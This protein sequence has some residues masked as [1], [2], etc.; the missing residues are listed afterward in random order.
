MWIVNTFQYTRPCGRDHFLHHLR[1]G[2]KFQ[3]TLPCGRDVFY[4][5]K[6]SDKKYFNTLAHAGETMRNTL[7]GLNIIF[8]YTRP[9]GRDYNCQL[10]YQS[11][12][13]I[14]IHSPMRARLVRNCKWWRF[15]NFNTLAHAGETANLHKLHI[16]LL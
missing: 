15:S 1:E 7:G 5:V 13:T 9:C 11:R 8:Q 12:M 16:P 14:S 6:E 2:R 4:T 10:Q 3:Y